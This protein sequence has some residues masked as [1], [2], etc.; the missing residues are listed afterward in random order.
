MATLHGF[1]SQS[2]ANLFGYCEYTTPT[3]GKNVFVTD[4]VSGEGDTIPLPHLNSSANYVGIVITAVRRI[5][6][7]NFCEEEELEE[8]RGEEDG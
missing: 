5:E 7:E 3:L 2:D 4:V 6:P 1:F 8:G